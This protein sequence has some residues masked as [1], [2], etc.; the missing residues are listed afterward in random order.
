M[1]RFTTGCPHPQVTSGARTIR[2]RIAAL[3]AGGCLIFS[4][5][6]WAFESGRTG[7]TDFFTLGTW[8]VPGGLGK[9][10]GQFSGG[11]K[12]I[13]YIEDLHCHYEVQMK[14]AEILH[15]LTEQYGLTLVG[16]EGAFHTVNAYQLSS[17]PES[18]A[19][20]EAGRFLVR[21]GR[22]SGAEYYAGNGKN[23]IQLVGIEKPE[24][25]LASRAALD[26][27]LNAESLGVCSDLRGH[28]NQLK[29]LIYNPALLR[30]DAREQAYRSGAQD[31]SEYLGYAAGLAEK[32]HLPLDE[33]PEIVRF[34]SV[35]K[36]VQT[37]PA[38]SANLFEELARL[39]TGLRSRL[40]TQGDQRLLDAHLHRLDIIEKMLNISATREEVR[41]FTSQR[42][43]FSVA[44]FHQFI[45]GHGAEK[46][47]DGEPE[48]IRL[49]KA[50][51]AAEQFYHLADQRSEMFVRNLTRQM[52][53]RHQT[54]AV[55]IAGG[56]HTGKV[57]R[58]LRQAKIGYIAITP[59]L[60]SPDAANPYFSLLQKRKTPLEK[61][62]SQ[63]QI[64]L[65]PRT[66]L[67]D[68]EGL[69]T[70]EKTG[71]FERPEQWLLHRLLASAGCM[72]VV[73]RT[74]RGTGRS[75]AAVERAHQ[76]LQAWGGREPED[77][78]NLQETGLLNRPA[79]PG[80][81]A[82]A[83]EGF[84]A[85]GSLGKSE[86]AFAGSAV[87][88]LQAGRVWIFGRT[89]VG[90][91][92]QTLA[93]VS[94]HPT[95]HLGEGLARAVKILGGKFDAGSLAPGLGLGRIGIEGLRVVGMLP[96]GA[97]DPQA[98]PVGSQGN[99]RPA[100]AG[101]VH[102]HLQKEDIAEL[103]KLHRE[104]L[105]IKM[106]YREKRIGGARDLSRLWKEARARLAKKIK[107][108]AS[109]DWNWLWEQGDELLFQ[110]LKM[111]AYVVADHLD[112][113]EMMEAGQEQVAKAEWVGRELYRAAGLARGWRNEE[114]RQRVW[115]ILKQHHLPEEM[116]RFLLTHP[117]HSP[118]EMLAGLSAG[119]E[120]ILPAGMFARAYLTAKPAMLWEQGQEIPDHREAEK[121][122]VLEK[123]TGWASFHPGD[124]IQILDHPIVA[125][126][127]EGQEL[128]RPKTVLVIKAVRV[129]ESNRTRFEFILE[130]ARV[131]ASEQ[132]AIPAWRVSNYAKLP[133][134][135]FGIG[136]AEIWRAS[137]PWSQRFREGG[138]LGDILWRHV[139]LA[140]LSLR[141]R[142][143]AGPGSF[144]GKKFIPPGAPAG[145]AA[146]R[147]FSRHY[148]YP[149]D[150]SSRCSLDALRS[151]MARE[152]RALA[153]NPFLQ[154]H[155][156]R[157]VAGSEDAV[158]AA[159]MRLVGLKI[160]NHRD[161]QELKLRVW[162]WWGAGNVESVPARPRKY[163]R[164]LGSA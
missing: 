74:L 144:S 47:P 89:Q 150:P 16:M 87:L 81:V 111:A 134:A 7:K 140:G 142:L 145:A 99:Y 2:T 76:V 54:A 9:I 48:A 148:F 61:L 132:V 77:R 105:R 62:L 129:R 69:G 119:L 8:S 59:N 147:F 141:L 28:I 149:K 114:A 25:Y 13:I 55:M 15:Y 32:T 51:N 84:T 85:V 29:P 33:F 45:E 157:G 10:T 156:L 50:M 64:L 160:E 71:G 112:R 106:E 101:Q 130:A 152:W 103:L 135:E 49:E 1:V 155:W 56:F 113:D 40:Y 67:I 107:F 65:A 12:L 118:A 98:A 31:L 161:T 4:S 159:A 116:S 125:E 43:R 80:V 97:L 139:S 26:L 83:T 46:I 53:R 120:K 11:E 19:R 100:K 52:E 133:S 42:P 86:Q 22:L 23:T 96:R 30:L 143:A 102:G 94:G 82:I 121:Q 163:T 70:R 88:P 104:V 39:E 58:T 122:R 6:G 63:D 34:L 92:K 115:E 35:G 38:A 146:A 27:F 126:S 131:G 91:A 60:S 110:W 162:R 72:S 44:A 14:I 117:E 37:R 24:Y 164:A 136:G 20:E 5:L 128:I 18:A 66:G 124:Q 109:P 95:A 75:E 36:L 79:K 90:E 21:Q 73:L 151:L 3:L 138:T 127:G 153:I 68:R 137:E 93:A 123:L 108:P 154:E 41:E 78:I 17:F 57:L 158:D